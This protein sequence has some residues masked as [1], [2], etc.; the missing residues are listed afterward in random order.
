M[1]NLC[2]VARLDDHPLPIKS[3]YL[4]EL[5]RD[6]AIHALDVIFNEHPNGKHSR[7]LRLGSIAKA[8]WTRDSR[9]YK[10]LVSSSDLARQHLVVS[11][12]DISLRNSIVFEEDF[13]LAKLQASSERLEEISNE[14]P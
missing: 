13:R 6:A 14:H 1:N 2:R 12:G 8:V 11:E 5:M 4:K 10:I 7:L 9:L 3:M